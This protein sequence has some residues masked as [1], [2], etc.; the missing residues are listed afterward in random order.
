MLFETAGFHNPFWNTM[1][2]VRG[3]FYRSSA[4]HVTRGK[5]YFSKD[6]RLK[7]TWSRVHPTWNT[8]KHLPDDFRWRFTFGTIFFEWVEIIT[9]RYATGVSSHPALG[10]EEIEARNFEH[11]KRSNWVDLSGCQPKNRGKPPQIILIFTIHFGV[12]LFLETTIFRISGWYSPISFNGGLLALHSRNLIN[13]G[14]WKRICFFQMLGCPAVRFLGG[15]REVIQNGLFRTR[16]KKP[17]INKLSAKIIIVISEGPSSDRKHLCPSTDKLTRKGHLYMIVS[18]IAARG[19]HK[20]IKNT[21]FC[22]TRPCLLVN[23]R[24]HLFLVGCNTLVN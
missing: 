24:H 19:F 13:G 21:G 12:P 5:C 16:G 14:P 1:S 8:D 10:I 20:P 7:K 4:F 3:R 23:V 17:R 15:C 18:T 22:S 6:G 2:F 11:Q 9:N